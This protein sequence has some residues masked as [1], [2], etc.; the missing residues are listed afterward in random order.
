MNAQRNVHRDDMS[1]P[2]D[3]V[4]ALVRATNEAMEA[5]MNTDGGN[6]KDEG[7]VSINPLMANPAVMMAAAT[8]YGIRMTGQWATMFLNALQDQAATRA[9]E[10]APEEPSGTE[11]VA[12]ADI[13]ASKDAPVEA[14]TAVVAEAK[15]EA[16]AESVAPAPRKGERRT[17][18][19]TRARKPA[20]SIA[21]GAAQNSADD[22]KLISGIGPKLANVLAGRGVATFASLADMDEAALAALDQE[23][24]LEGRVLRDDWAGQARKIMASRG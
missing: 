18:K 3:A 6:D 10:A 24:G 16:E 21:V 5:L 8:A 20:A 12:T 9:A 11:N 19:V 7:G 17:I 22:L 23:L 13:A 1:A 14:A 2:H 4:A 15:V